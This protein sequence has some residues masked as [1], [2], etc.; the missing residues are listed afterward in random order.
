MSKKFFAILCL[1][2]RRVNWQTNQALIFQE[3]AVLFPQHMGIIPFL[4][5]SAIDNWDFND[6]SSEKKNNRCCDR[7]LDDGWMDDMR[8]Y[9]LFSHIRPM[10]G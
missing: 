7:P 5:S 9:V 2:E 10:K 4:Y 8:I 3:K 1:C 6:I